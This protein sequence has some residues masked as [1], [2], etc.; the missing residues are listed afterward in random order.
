MDIV[1][2]RMQI[3]R[4]ELKEGETLGNGRYGYRNIFHGM[5]L[6]FQRE[7][8]LGYFRGCYVRILYM[9]SQAALN[10]TLI[11]Y[12]RGRILNYIENKK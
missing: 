4:A 9:S 12:L 10:L 8:F 11:D 1:K 2:V 5:L 3:Q 7:G 6:V